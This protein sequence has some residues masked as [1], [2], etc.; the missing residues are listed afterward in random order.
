[1]AGTIFYAGTLGGSINPDTILTHREP[2]VHLLIY[3]SIYSGEQGPSHSRNRKSEYYMYIS[4]LLCLLS[5]GEIEQQSLVLISV[6][7]E[8][9]ARFPQRLLCDAFL[10]LADTFLLFKS[11]GSY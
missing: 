4:V 7:V 10:S 5:D 11:E 1:M 8:P 6:D 2:Q 3:S 9:K